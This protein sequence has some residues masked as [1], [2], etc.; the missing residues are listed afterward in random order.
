M[1]LSS[2]YRVLA[3]DNLGFGK[4]DKGHANYSVRFFTQVLRELIEREDLKKVTLVGHSLG[5]AIALRYLLEDPSRVKRAVV[6]APAGIRLPQHRIL[7]MIAGLMLRSPMARGTLA[8]SL[9][10]CAVQRTE[11]VLDMMFHAHGLPDDPEW[12]QIRHSLQNT[13][14]NLMHFTLHGELSV[15]RTPLLVVWGEDDKLL[16]AN[17][18]LK[19][20]QEVPLARLAI[21]PDCGHYP[22]LEQP[23]RFHRHLREFLADEEF[24]EGCEH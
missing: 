9:E 11:A 5:G 3:Y 17:L 12:R 20:H 6:V 1:D 4:S 23:E 15:I 19:I 22:M 24:I 8:R 7:R 14:K 10:R 18:A 2:H 13:A 21:V 16:P